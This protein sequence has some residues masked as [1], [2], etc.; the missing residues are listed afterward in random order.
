MIVWLHGDNPEDKILDMT[1]FGAVQENLNA[2]I[3]MPKGTLPV[4]LKT[5]T[6][7]DGTDQ[8]TWNS[9]PFKDN[10]NFMTRSSGE[11]NLVLRTDDIGFIEQLITHITA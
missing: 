6:T 3:L 5:G 2:A 7:P 11:K 1:E 10:H 9:A 4:G 8:Y